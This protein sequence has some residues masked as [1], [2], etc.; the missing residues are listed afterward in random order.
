MTRMQK[1]ELHAHMAQALQRQEEASRTDRKTVPARYN[2]LPS[3]KGELMGVSEETQLQSNSGKKMVIDNGDSNSTVS[4]SLTLRPATMEQR[5]QEFEL[6][7]PVIETIDN[8][9]YGNRIET[10]TQ[11]GD[12]VRSRDE[13]LESATRYLGGSTGASGPNEGPTSS[14]SGGASSSAIPVKALNPKEAR[15]R[16]IEWAREKGLLMASLPSQWTRGSSNDK[17]GQEHHAFPFA[18][19]GTIRWLK[20]TKGNG[21]N[22]GLWP[23]DQ[24]RDWAL[25]PKGTI[26]DYLRRIQDANLLLGED[27][28]L[29]G[30]LQDPQS[31]AVSIVTS[32][33]HVVE[34]AETKE[35][36]VIDAMESQ[37][38]LMAGNTATYYRASDNLAIFDAHLGNVARVGETLEAF[39]VIIMSPEG[40]LKQYLESAA[41][42]RVKDKDDTTE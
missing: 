8:L 21:T 18:V 12:S 39:D 9:L 10:Q 36:D 26:Q 20:A 4:Q 3:R 34:T 2:D 23:K 31:G 14:A 42:N 5:S 35:Q 38:F 29:H 22:F 16:L 6:H 15:R 1:P 19:G 11:A 30:V 32:Q 25:E 37:G 13:L 41:Q 40:R 33:R 27:I 28:I 17:A 24:G 7:R